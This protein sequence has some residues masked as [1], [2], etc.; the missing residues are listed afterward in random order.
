MAKL[1]IFFRDLDNSIQIE[2]A[3][4]LKE[5]LQA[6]IEDAV[7][8]T[9]PEGLNAPEEKQKEIADE[10]VDDYINRNDT[11]IEFEI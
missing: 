9:C 1:K 10:V 8:S 2:L 11:G 5:E 4:M 6:E 3:E 7:E